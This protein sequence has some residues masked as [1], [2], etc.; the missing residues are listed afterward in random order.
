MV[1]IPPRGEYT[2]GMAE[3]EGIKFLKHGKTSNGE[4]KYVTPYFLVEPKHTSSSSSTSDHKKGYIVLY[5]HGNAED[6]FQL[7]DLLVRYA[8]HFN[9][10]AWF[11]FDYG[12]YSLSEPRVSS[13]QR[14]YDD[15][16]ACYSFIVNTLNYPPSQVIIFGRSLGSGIAT[17]LA[18]TLSQQYEKQVEQASGVGAESSSSSSSFFSSFSSKVSC[19]DLLLVRSSSQ[20]PYAGLIL[21]SPIE[22]VVRVVATSVSY[23]TADMFKNFQKIGKTMKPVLV[24]HGVRDEVVPFSHGQSLSKIL[25]KRNKLHQFVQLEDAGHNDIEA[26]YFHVVLDAIKLFFETFQPL[27]TTTDVVV[28]DNEKTGIILIDNQSDSS[29]DSSD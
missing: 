22:S 20:E 13:E 5:C 3:T 9:D 8:Q 21:Q 19:D 18:F 23:I 28:K 11:G 17:H 14:C 24:I 10:Y 26:R 6:I 16:E 2:K 4:S 27:K 1:F 29:S 25:R 15:V 7:K 12:G